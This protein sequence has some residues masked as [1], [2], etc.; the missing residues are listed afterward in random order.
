MKII[1]KHALAAVVGYVVMQAVFKTMSPFV[2]AGQVDTAG[3]QAQIN[4]PALNEWS[5]VINA[6][7]S[8]LAVFKVLDQQH[9]IHRQGFMRRGHCVHIIGFP[10]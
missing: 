3:G 2:L 9:G 4:N 6:D 5:A 10:V 7:Y 1:K 8:L